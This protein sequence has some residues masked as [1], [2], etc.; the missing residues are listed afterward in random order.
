VL[1]GTKPSLSDALKKCNRYLLLEVIDEVS[2]KSFTNATDV[3]EQH[4]CFAGARRQSLRS[5][6]RY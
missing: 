2:A 5:V 3:G 1:R 6:E 4:P